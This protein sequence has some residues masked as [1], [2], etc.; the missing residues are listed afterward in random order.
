VATFASPEWSLD[1][2]KTFQPAYLDP[3]DELY[4]LT[5]KPTK[6]LHEH[7]V[8]HEIAPTNGKAKFEL[9][10]QNKVPGTQECSCY[11]HASGAQ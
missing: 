9:T 7:M 11:Q 4:A 5:F 1:Y 6:D 8:E 2:K 3:K 10:R